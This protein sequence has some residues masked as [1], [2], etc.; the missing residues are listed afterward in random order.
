MSGDQPPITA[1]AG[2]ARIVSPWTKID[3]QEQQRP[4]LAGS[5]LGVL[6]GMGPMAGAAFVMRL[7]AL[8]PACA[9]QAHIPTLLR[10]DPRIPDRSQAKI[11][12]G[13]S[14]LASMLQGVYALQTAG[15]GLIVIP[16]N[17]AHFWYDE[18]AAAVSVPILHIVD[19]VADELARQGVT[20]GPVGILGTPA[21]LALGLYQEHL[22][23]R[24]YTCLLPDSAQT[25]QACSTAIL[26]V[27][28]N[29][30]ELA[31][32]P[33]QQAIDDMCRQGARAV[34]LGCTELPL[35]V[36]DRYRRTAVPIADSID[37]LARAAITH[38]PDRARVIDLQSSMSA[39]HNVR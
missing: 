1:P 7:V 20:S 34:V 4:P 19:A 2:R 12:D 3:E 32:R 33:A 22:A 15:A 25:H 11:A 35:A 30:P 38:R 36:P 16:C 21:T 17:T 18:L 9:D 24:G 6:G 10:N 26:A 27:K 37:A 5:Y 28:A 29:R 23:R 31:I 13:E 39:A 14:P 8:T